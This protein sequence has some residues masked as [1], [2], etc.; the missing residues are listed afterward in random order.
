MTMYRASRSTQNR[1]LGDAFFQ[2]SIV[3]FAMDIKFHIHIHSHVHGLTWIS[4]DIFISIDAYP[5][6]G[7]V[8][9]CT[10]YNV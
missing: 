7:P 5:L 6:S 1:S 2:A 10:K 4:M 9:V 8:T 3:R